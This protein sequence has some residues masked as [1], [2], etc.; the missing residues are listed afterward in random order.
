MEIFS[1]EWFCSFEIISELFPIKHLPFLSYRLDLRLL[2]HLCKALECIYCVL[3]KVQVV[4]AV[5][6]R[7][8]LV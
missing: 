5:H 4:F 6:K 2:S 7:F 1:P 8:G 3:I